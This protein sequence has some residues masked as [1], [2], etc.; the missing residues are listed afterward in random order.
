MTAD[1]IRARG[2]DWRRAFDSLRPIT[3]TLWQAMDDTLRRRFLA[4]WRRT[5]EVHRSRVSAAVM[6]DV[7]GWVDTGRLEIRAGGIER[8][9]VVGARLMISG[10]GG[11]SGPGGRGWPADR[12]LLATGPD[13]AAAANPL[14]ASTIAQGLLAPGPLGLGLDADPATLQV[15][16]RSGSVMPSVYAIGPLLRGVLWE[17]IAIP[18]IR[19]QA[20]RIAGQIL[21][22]TPVR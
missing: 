19:A 11:S 6:R 2:D 14:L 17:T 18:E 15:R 8:V 21:A 16:D 10:P 7:R 3:P 22:A 20:V 9:D 5:W 4:D 1:R 13:E 12:I